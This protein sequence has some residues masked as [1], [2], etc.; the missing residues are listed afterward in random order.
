M[1][2]PRSAPMHGS[3]A[4]WSVYHPIAVIMLTLASLVLGLFLLE[5][6]KIGLLPH[7][8]YPSIGVRVNAP[9]VPAKIMEDQVTRQLEEQ[10]SITEDAIHIRSSTREGRSA[11]DLDFAYGKDIDIALRDASTRLDRAKRFLPDYVQAPIIYK[12]DPSQLPA[13]EYA[14]SSTSM[15]TTELKEWT[16]YNL[17]KWLINIPGV[18]AAE[19][20]GGSQ[21]EIQVLANPD[22]LTALK[23]DIFQLEKLLQDENQDVAGG[24]IHMADGELPLQTRGRLSN[25]EQIRQLPVPVG[26]G[27]SLPLGEI[28]Q[29]IDGHEES[30]LRIRLNQQAAVKLSI[31]KQPQANSVAVVDRVN[32]QLQAL[33]QQGIIQQ[34]IQVTPVS[35]EARHI[36]RALSNA[37]GAALSGA[38]LA[39]LVVYLF[40]G[41]LRLTLII[42][43]AIPIAILM[44]LTLMS[45]SNLTLNIMTLG[46]LALGIG[47][48]VDNTIVMLENIYRHQLRQDSP[49]QAAVAAAAEVNSPIIA[50]TS[51]NL[52][53]VLPFLFIGGLIGLLFQE[54]IIT[55][56]AAILASMMV[57]LTL[58]PAL[59]GSMRQYP[60]HGLRGL[61]EQVMH[62]LETAYGW[63]LSHL[64]K[65]SWLV[66]ALFIVALA[67]LLPQLNQPLASF[68]PKV[69][70][71]R[72]GIYLTADRGTDVDQMDAITRRIETLVL[73]QPET[74]TVLAT[75]GGFT[76]GRSKY[77]TAHRAN[78][79]VQ[80]LPA[81][82]RINSRD[83]ARKLTQAIKALNLVGV[84]VRVR[85]HG[86]RG[87][88]LGRGDDEINFQIKGPDLQILEHLGQQMEQILKPMPGLKNIKRSNE[89][90][91]LELAIDVDKEL[92]RRYRLTT[93]DIGKRVRYSMEGAIVSHYTR[94]DRS[95]DIRLRIGRN[96][97]Y[98]PADLEQ[99]VILG[100]DPARTPIRLGSIATIKLV[101]APA[102]IIREQQQRIVEVN[103]SLSADA[104]LQ[105]TLEQ[106]RQRLTQID[107][108]TGYSLYE[109]G[110]LLTLQQGKQMGYQLIG[111]A[112][113]LVFVV[114][115]V[116]YES[117]RNP[118]III[119]SVAFSLI[120]VALGLKWTQTP[121]SMP[122]W[123][124]MIMLAGIVVNNAI[125]LVE[126]IEL[127]KNCGRE[128]L[129]AIIAAGRTR[130]RP[131]LMTTLTTVV[132][133]LPLALGIGEGSEML[134][135][136]A[137]TLVS[138]LSFSMLVSLILVP[139]VYRYL[140]TNQPQSGS[141]QCHQV[142]KNSSC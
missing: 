109:G 128:K 136:L 75:V 88:R 79:Q 28:A 5:H 131:I 142:K 42:G 119:F 114:M 93:E 138:G 141:S 133:M 23:L 71:G 2:K 72:I 50:A 123:L 94:N 10:L 47:M 78:L 103:A 3:I 83:W 96:R 97:L 111:L 48:L 112:L 81:T 98:S 67:W 132:G 9:G 105:Q 61:T 137:I 11:V 6:L 22:E 8:I 60:G 63:L 106:A 56:S 95:I 101:F 54:L 19:V 59:A 77:E 139:S 14:I 12:R 17:G 40:L 87:L 90:L 117:L 39:M 49:A 41:S 108:P 18:A 58:V 91:T 43:S 69:D 126:Y 52:A 107:L 102:T 64:L 46:G 116:Q 34:Q 44:T 45:A 20:A 25:A 86:I 115:A 80:L 26:A 129:H 57:A 16:D 120:G 124:G 135:P 125:I 55:I 82:E 85:Q 35:D 30:R 29:V 37:I 7:I 140:G 122:V 53:A 51:T 113:F 65:W 31:Q 15:D 134:Q 38:A 66:I 32:Q 100:K 4:G 127:E 62:Q 92:A 36:R 99:L 24:R 110:T 74:A 73:Q 1:V 21:R 118:L 70:D 76:F 33:Q 68:L 84:K 130:L 13:A 27:H 89:D 104:N 121:I